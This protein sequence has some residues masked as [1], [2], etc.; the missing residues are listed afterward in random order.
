MYCP[1]T[2]TSYSFSK[3]IHDQPA[4]A[5]EMVTFKHFLNKLDLINFCKGRSY[6]HTNTKKIPQQPTKY[7][8]TLSLDIAARY[9]VVNYLI[10]NLKSGMRQINKTLINNQ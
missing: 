1:V 4:I 10:K 6:T 9:P 3:N 8:F 5:N 7:Q 2:S